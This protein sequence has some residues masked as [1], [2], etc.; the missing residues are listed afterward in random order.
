MITDFWKVPYPT[1]NSNFGL[2]LSSRDRRW[3]LKPECLWH[4]GLRGH[5]SNVGLLAWCGLSLTLCFEPDQ[6][7]GAAPRGRLSFA[8]RA[9]HGLRRW[10]S[11]SC[12][13]R[14]S[15]C[16]RTD[17]KR[18]TQ[19]RRDAEQ[20]E[21]SRLGRKVPWVVGFLSSVFSAP[22]RL[23]VRTVPGTRCMT[24]AFQRPAPNPFHLLHPYPRQA[25]VR[26][27][28]RRVMD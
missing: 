11:I 9:Y 19:R 7:P 10:D 25:R 13:G 3:G 4:P 6:I 5:T 23:R 21:Q 26:A 12:A 24:C 18:L 1:K 17:R 8:L 15:A 27:L 16:P 14:K 2:F 22:L 28:A 20:G